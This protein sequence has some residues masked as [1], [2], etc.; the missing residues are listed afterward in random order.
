MDFIELAYYGIFALITLFVLLN[1]G[2]F[3]FAGIKNLQKKG[4]K[5][6]IVYIYSKSGYM[7]QKIWDW[8]NPKDHGDKER[9]GYILEEATIGHKAGIPIAIVSSD[10]VTAVWSPRGS[11]ESRV[12]SQALNSHSIMM[13][14]VGKAEVTMQAKQ[15]QLLFYMCMGILVICMV[16]AYLV[17]NNSEVLPKIGMAV[18]SVGAQVSTLQS[19][20]ANTTIVN[21][22]VTTVLN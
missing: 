1:E 14:E 20:L 17:W 8:H 13:E 16:M 9:Q 7:K 6:G 10:D 12:D 2:P 5:H 15:T 22:S 18:E 4:S 21:Q 3:V 11:K 19:S